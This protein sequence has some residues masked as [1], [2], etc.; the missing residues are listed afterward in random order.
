MRLENRD[1]P[2]IEA[3]RIELCQMRQGTKDAVVNAS[4]FGRLQFMSDP[5]ELVGA[6]AQGEG[7]A[8]TLQAEIDQI[9]RL[10]WFEKFQQRVIDFAPG[11][12]KRR[13]A[14]HE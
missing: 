11:I 14:R 3:G 10:A 7:A 9:V 1:K 8:C 5:V 12:A 6:A 4:L 2:R 13:I